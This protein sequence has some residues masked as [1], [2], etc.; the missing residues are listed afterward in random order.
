MGIPEDSTQLLVKAV[1]GAKARPPL[2]NGD[3]IVAIDGARCAEVADL[4]QVLPLLQRSTSLTLRVERPF[5]GV[6]DDDAE[7]PKRRRSSGD[8]WWRRMLSWAPA[9]SDEPTLHAVWKSNFRR[10][11]SHTTC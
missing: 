4:S 7:P 11:T 3:R 2:R 6:D 10:D 1:V 5:R 9:E 8:S